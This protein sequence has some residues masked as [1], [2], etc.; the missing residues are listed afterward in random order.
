[1]ISGYYGRRNA[2]DEAILGGMLAELR[3]LRRDA[4][5]RVVSWDPEGTRRLH[6]VEAVPW[7]DGSGVIDAVRESSLVIVGGGGLFHDY[8]AVEPEAMLTSR[9]AGIA[10]YGAPI[11]LARLLGIPSMLYAVGVGPLRTAEGRDLT[12]EIFDAADGATLR[13]AASRSLLAEIGCPVEGIEVVPD[14]AFHLPASPQDPATAEVLAG[15]QRPILGVSLRFWSFDVDP[16]EWEAQVAAAL[17]DHRAASGGTALFVPL[18]DGAAEVEDDVSVSRRVMDR[19]ARPEQARLAP[20]GL[21]PLQRFRLLEACDGVLGMRLHAAVAGLRAGKPVIALAYDPKVTALMAAAG[22]AEAALAPGEWTAEAIGGALTGMDARGGDRRAV[23]A[24]ASPSSMASVDMAARLLERGRGPASPGE[25]AQRRLM[26][27][28]LHE[29]IRLESEVESQTAALRSQLEEIEALKARAERQTEVISRSDRRT[30]ELGREK[31]ELQ[32]QLDTLRNTLGFRTLAMYWALVNRALPPG[33]R[34]RRLAASIRRAVPGRRHGWASPYG[35]LG[36]LE[37]TGSSP[38]REELAS[39]LQRHRNARP[40]RAALILAPTPLDPDEGQRS[41]HL[42]FELARR[43]VPV[44]FGYWRWRTDER[45]LQSETGRGIVQIPLDELEAS[46]SLA[47]EAFGEAQRLLLMEFPHP[48]FFGLAAAARGRGWISVYDLVDDWEEFHRA[49]QAPW[50]R[51]DFESHL[52]ATADSVVAVSPG[53]AARARSLARREAELIP[54]GVGPGF[55]MVHEPRRLERGSVTLGYFGHLTRAWFDWDL[56]RRVGQLRPDWRIHLL[57]YGDI[58]PARLPG[59]VILHGKVRRE[60]LASYASHW[61]VG[62][63]PFK[64]SRLAASADPIKLYEYLALGLPV[65]AAGVTPPP[66][67]DGL[68]VC[69]EDERS[70][71][72]E[73]LRAV[74]REPEEVERRRAFADGCTWER[75]VDRLLELLDRGDQRIGLQRSLFEAEE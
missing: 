4:R 50:Y 34:R 38:G 30:Q 40:Q 70:F 12:R 2:G 75:R 27:R 53:L 43:G 36:Y 67:V 47:L 23:S 73:V 62:I 15:L 44:I 35:A 59:N 8:W 9:Q 71:I 5:F 18:Q 28:R 26:L 54:N 48:S 52:L 16:S 17:D 66:G 45:R 10:Q 19:M 7:A 46:P 24:A 72:A 65:V 13:D 31:E 25:A 29:S 55:A 68:V 14:P 3:A 37:S 32:R 39:F 1:L 49:G 51:P 56:V 6:G 33:T 69:A 64:R 74:A 63:I 41:T 20:A 21:D 42:A 11:V 58:A 22:A 61:D 57:G 60:E